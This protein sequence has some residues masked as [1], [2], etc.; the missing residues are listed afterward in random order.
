MI[1]MLEKCRDPIEKRIISRNISCKTDILENLVMGDKI[2]VR[3]N[4]ISQANIEATVFMNDPFLGELRLTILN[5]DGIVDLKYEDVVNSLRSMPNSYSLETLNA[6]I[7]RSVSLD[8]GKKTS[9]K[10]K[11]VEKVN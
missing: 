8:I 7:P 3:Q 10:E 2:F 11:T 5:M 1:F 6:K 4:L 9:I